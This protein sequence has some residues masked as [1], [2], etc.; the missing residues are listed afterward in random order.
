MEIIMKILF[1]G[2]SITD[3]GRARDITESDAKLGTGYV[4]AAAFK[5]YEKSID[6]YQVYNRGISGNRIVDLYARVKSDLWNLEPDVISILIGIND[7]WHEVVR[8]NGVELDR[9]ENI[10]RILLRETRERLPKAKIIL[11][12]PFVLKA[13]ATE[14]KY[15][16]FLAAFDYAKVVRKLS[17][18]FGTYFLPLQEV[19]EEAG[20]KYGNAQILADGVHPTMKGASIIA[21][22]WI[23]VFEKLERE[24]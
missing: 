7:V 17:E 20:E 1:F 23:N 2:D 14:E 11:C 10:Y 13:E 24:L 8:K 15:D 22:R 18:E 12:E 4:S 5:L 6:K 16:S 19:I 9:F 3:A 21:N